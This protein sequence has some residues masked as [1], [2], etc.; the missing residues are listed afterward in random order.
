MDA[1]ND[2]VLTAMKGAYSWE[3]IKP[4]VNSLKRSG[5]RGKKVI[6]AHGL[7]PSVAEELKRDGFELWWYDIKEDRTFGSY[8]SERFW[9]AND[10]LRSFANEHRYIIWVDWKDLVIQT[11]PSVWL[12]VHMAPYKIIGCTEGMRV[13]EEFYNNGWM[14]QAAPDHYH[15]RSCP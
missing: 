4:F 9:P 2:L 12:E 1:T 14:K 5:F 8:C 11:D 6:L 7:L 13:K 3:Q 15:I 10:F